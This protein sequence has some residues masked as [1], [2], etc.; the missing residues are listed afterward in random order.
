MAKKQLMERFDCDEIGKLT[1]YIGCKID[2][3]DGYMKLTQPVL[4]QSFQDEFDIP[5]GKTPSTLAIPGEVLR[6]GMEGGMLSEAMQ[7]K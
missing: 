3:G 6:S 7:S 1:E 5:E 2:R 4:L